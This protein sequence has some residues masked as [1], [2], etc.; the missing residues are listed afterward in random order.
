[1]SAEKI[2]TEEARLI[3]L[4]ELN[5]QEPNFS[6]S[7]S[8]LQRVLRAMFLIVWDRSRVEQELAWLAE[9][10]AVRLTE[11]GSVVIATLKE[12]G[13][14][15]LAHEKFLAGIQRTQLPLRVE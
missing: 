8:A 9:Q 1:M 13:R 6:L 11:A 10:G 15:H 14:M 7:S 2:V 5:N 12:A 4:R 3:I